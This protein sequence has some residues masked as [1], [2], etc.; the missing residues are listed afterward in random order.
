[1]NVILKPEEWALNLYTNEQ[2]TNK[3]K[4]SNYIIKEIYGNEVL[5]FHTITW[6]I[7]VLT[8]EEYDNILNNEYL[9][10]VNVIVDN[11]LDEL[12]I[13]TQAYRERMVK[14]NLPTYDRINSY[15]V[16]TTTACNAR[17]HY[18][19][20]TNLEKKESMTLETAE[21]LVQ[22]ILKHHYP[23][24]GAKIQ[25]FGGEPL[26]NTKVIDYVSKRLD[27]LNVKYYSTMI[28]NSLLFNEENV[29]KIDNWKMKSVQITIDGLNET[30][31]KIKNYVYSD[32]DAFLVLIENIHRLIDKTDIHITLRFNIGNDNIF[33]MYDTI[34]YIKEEFKDYIGNRVSLYAS[35]LYEFNDES[36]APIDG[37]NDELKR[38]SQ[39][40][41]VN[42][43]DNCVDGTDTETFKRTPINKMCMAYNGT[44]I[45]IL[46]NGSFSPC[47]HVKDEDIFGNII[48]GITDYSVIERW[49]DLGNDEMLSFCKENSCPLHALCS[50]FF[51]CSEIYVCK[52]KERQEYRLKGA[53]EKLI[54]TY[55]Y[56][57]NEKNKL[58]GGK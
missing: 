35:R 17:C 23:K 9:K 45:A 4:L 29:S 37:Y 47:E 26:L 43:P 3:T 55:E 11:N 44:G 10:S 41:S 21:N 27:E 49:Q 22:F 1:M 2:Q 31:N 39:L 33:E 46:P 14:K 25:W 7:Y 15:V 8:L 57:L 36:Y 16:F 28:S 12:K 5:L 52:T 53:K 51:L 19:Y 6:S 24:S 42:T 18:C 54:K 13:A 40:C 48:D 20:E 56:Y 32:I 38:I 50:R 58:K 34:E 30:Y